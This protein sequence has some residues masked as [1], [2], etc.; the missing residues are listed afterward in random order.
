VAK[1]F[2]KSNSGA[3]NSVEITNKIK[4]CLWDEHGITL[5]DFKAEMDGFYVE[6]SKDKLNDVYVNISNINNPKYNRNKLA[7]W[8]KDLGIKVYRLDEDKVQVP[9]QSIGM[10]IDLYDELEH[11]FNVD[12]EA[13]MRQAVAL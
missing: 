3:K 8:L 7:G 5:R 6:S 4:R 12:Q 2:S 11:R 9:Y 10:I 13:D 1:F